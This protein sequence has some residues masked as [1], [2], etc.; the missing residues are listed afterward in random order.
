MPVVILALADRLDTLAGLFA[1]GLKPTGSADPYGLRRQ[2]LGLVRILTEKHG[3]RFSLREGIR[4]AAEGLP[5]EMTEEAQK[6]LWEFT[7]QRLRGRMQEFL[8]YDVVEAIL[9]EQADNP[10]RALFSGEVFNW[11]IGPN[12]VKFQELLPAYARTARIIPYARSRGLAPET[13]PFPLDPEALVEP[14][15]RALYEA[16]QKAR[17]EVEG[18]GGM[19]EFLQAM[20]PLVEPI[21][22]F[23]DQVLVVAQDEA[24]RDQSEEV[25]LR[26]NRLALLQR[27]KELAE[28]W[29]DFSKLEGY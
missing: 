3:I 28:G 12:L 7:V 16:Y 6:E 14:A 1:V 4:R 20:L 23:F 27:I 29:L 8:S 11:W 25:A 18:A 13:D 2:A 17:E 24:R 10:Y 19:A 15:S 26:H 5:M 21:N 22:T 9:G